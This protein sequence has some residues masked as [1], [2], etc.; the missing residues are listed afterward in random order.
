[1]LAMITTHPHPVPGPF[2]PS[3]RLLV[4]PSSGIFLDLLLI[5][6]K[7]AISLRLFAAGWHII[8][9]TI[10]NTGSIKYIHV[11]HASA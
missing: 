7:K 4:P 6:W 9:P 3:Y 11:G 5:K 8:T 10:Q 2:S 1:M